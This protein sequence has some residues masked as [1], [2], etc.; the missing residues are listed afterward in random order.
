VSRAS[1]N[2]VRL[3]ASTPDANPHLAMA[4]SDA[5]TRL[6]PKPGCWLAAPWRWHRCIASHR[7]ASHRRRPL[8]WPGLPNHHH[9]THPVLPPGRLVA[10]AATVPCFF[11]P[12]RKLEHAWKPLRHLTPRR[13]R[14]FCLHSQNSLHQRQT[15]AVG[16]PTTRSPGA[17]GWPSLSVTLWRCGACCTWVR[18]S[19][20]EMNCR[21]GALETAARLCRDLTLRR[22]PGSLTRRCSVLHKGSYI[23][24]Y[25]SPLPGL[26]PE[27]AGAVC[28]RQAV[29]PSCRDLTLRHDAPCLQ[30]HGPPFCKTKLIS[31]TI[32]YCC[33]KKLDS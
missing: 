9:L 20:A 30:P 27:T 3:A 10:P 14:P 21:K 12:G 2:T 4:P 11:P 33:C 23:A 29:R 16:A 17:L 7:T 18:L 5:T 6:G 13:W 19:R 1:A 15:D 26:G 8:P 28:L 24:G 32:M 22:G 25:Y 31:Q